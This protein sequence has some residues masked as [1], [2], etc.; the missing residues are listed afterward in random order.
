[1]TRKQTRDFLGMRLQEKK[2]SIR[3]EKGKYSPPLKMYGSMWITQW[4]PLSY[5][6]NLL[7]LNADLLII[8]IK[9]IKMSA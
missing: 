2:C 1:M 6:A 5:I 3:E 8:I 4:N 9:Q 7:K